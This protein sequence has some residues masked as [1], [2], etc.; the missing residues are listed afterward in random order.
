VRPHVFWGG[1]AK[2]AK[3]KILKKISENTER[4]KIPMEV[5]K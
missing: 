3:I 2:L 5:V 4:G 1:T